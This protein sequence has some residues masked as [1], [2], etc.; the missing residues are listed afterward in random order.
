MR[1]LAREGETTIGILQGPVGMGDEG[2]TADPRGTE[3]VG[4]PIT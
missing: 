3:N 2:V 1:G 4:I